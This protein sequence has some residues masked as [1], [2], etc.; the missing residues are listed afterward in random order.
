MSN[1]GWT[2]RKIFSEIARL[3]NPLG[4]VSPVVAW[5]E[6]RMQHLWLAALDKDGIVPEGVAKK[7]EDF[8]TELPLLE[9][10]KVSRFMFV[11]E[12]SSVQFHV[13]SDASEVGYDGIYARSK[14]KEEN[15]RTELIASGPTQKTES[16]TTRALCCTP[17]GETIREGLSITADG[18]FLLS[19]LVGFNGHTPLDSRTSQHLANLHR[20]SDIGDP[21]IDPRSQLESCEKSRKPG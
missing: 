19:V 12:F 15:I 16:T 21:K 9:G 13:F 4:L 10:N 14:D 6:I 18:G 3:Y 2:K 17:G 20:E 7:L 1:D 5:A 8:V 11:K